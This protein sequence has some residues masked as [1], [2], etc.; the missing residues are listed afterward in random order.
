MC[1]PVSSK[2]GCENTKQNKGVQ[3]YNNLCKAVHRLTWT[4]RETPAE[5]KTQI[6]HKAVHK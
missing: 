5:A 6:K 3:V 4:S 1:K 2:Q